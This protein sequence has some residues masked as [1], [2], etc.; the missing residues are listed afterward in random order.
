MPDAI[1]CAFPHFRSRHL[2]HN[3]LFS[4]SIKMFATALLIESC[5]AISR[6]FFYREIKQ[7]SFEY[8]KIHS[9]PFH[10]FPMNRSWLPSTQWQHREYCKKEREVKKVSLIK[11]RIQSN[12][13]SSQVYSSATIAQLKC[14]TR[15]PFCHLPRP[16]AACLNKCLF[17]D[18]IECHK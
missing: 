17:I 4:T 5:T 16:L 8:N 6:N 11:F 9:L 2:C 18:F 3:F 15:T 7:K 1:Q 14:L 10:T 13:Q 12:A